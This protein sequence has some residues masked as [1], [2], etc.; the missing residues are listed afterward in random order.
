MHGV[1]ASGESSCC[2]NVAIRK[3]PGESQRAWTC[4]CFSPTSLTSTWKLS[5]P[6]T[7]SQQ[8]FQQW[9]FY[10]VIGY[11][12]RVALFITVYNTVLII[13]HLWSKFS[14]EPLQCSSSW[15]MTFGSPSILYN[16]NNADWMDKNKTKWSQDKQ[17][18]QLDVSLQFDISVKNTCVYYANLIVVVFRLFVLFSH[19]QLTHFPAKNY[20]SL[21]LFSPDCMGWRETVDYSGKE[22]GL[23][24]SFS[25]NLFSFSSQWESPWFALWL[26]CWRCIW[27]G[28]M[29]Q[30]PRKY[31]M[32]RK[33]EEKERNHKRFL[34]DSLSESVT[35]WQNASERFVGQNYTD[36]YVLGFWIEFFWANHW[37]VIPNLVL[38]T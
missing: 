33:E 16:R 10:L 22:F 23:A 3:L 14:Q 36:T 26:S 29:T 7:I 30:E 35:T 37:R 12:F 4:E 25:S 18:N 32:R 2:G 19:F 24:P 13:S 6:S 5:F 27:Q 9:R 21:I 28:L 38:A 15:S 1:T 8:L 11:I 31:Q 34:G 17:R 20:F